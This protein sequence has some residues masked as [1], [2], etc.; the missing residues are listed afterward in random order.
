MS[1]IFN[2][3]I[4]TTCVAGSVLER[5][6]GTV[7]VSTSFESFTYIVEDVEGSV[8]LQSSKAGMPAFSDALGYI[9]LEPESE[10][11]IPWNTA[12]EKE[13][14]LKGD[15]VFLNTDERISPSGENG[16]SDIVTWV[17]GTGATQQLIAL[18]GELDMNKV[19]TF[20][21]IVQSLS[22]SFGPNDQVRFQNEAGL[23]VAEPI[24]LAQLNGKS[25]KYIYLDRQ[26]ALSGIEPDQEKLQPADNTATHFEVQS[27]TSGTLVI[28]GIKAEVGANDLVGGWV[29]KTGDE[30][31][32]VR[33]KILGNTASATGSSQLTL[34]VGTSN[35][36]LL[37]SALDKV[38]LRG[39]EQQKL[40]II[41]YVESTAALLFG[42]LF[43][44]PLPFRTAPIYQRGVRKI[45]VGNKVEYGVQHNPLSGRNTFGVFAHIHEMRGD[46][47]IVNFGNFSIAYESD[48]IVVRAKDTT[49][50]VSLSDTPKKN[51]KIYTGISVTSGA[52]FLVINGKVRARSNI[53]GFEG[54]KTTPMVLTSAGLRHLLNISVFSESF[55]DLLQV[56]DM[57]PA[58][59]DLDEMFYT[60]FVP[61][62]LMAKYVTQI[63]L[64]SVVIPQPSG[65]RETYR[66]KTINAATKVLTIGDG[67]FFPMGTPVR[68]VRDGTAVASAVVASVSGVSVTLDHTTGMRVDD[69]IVP[70][71]ELPESRV[72]VV[73]PYVTSDAQTIQSVNTTNKT[74]VVASALAMV[75]GLA[76][77][78]TSLNQQ[79]ARVVITKVFQE[80]RTLELS[81][82]TDIEAGFIIGQ[83]VPGTEL[84]VSPDNYFVSLAEPNTAVSF[85]VKASDG[86]VLA[87]NTVPA[88]M[89]VRPL[90]N[91]YM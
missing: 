43:L 12:L 16:D 21:A 89:E 91:I 34:D 73:F 20:S 49:L 62:E 82:M 1:N 33:F 11:L 8:F 7:P 54:S 67:S 60:D 86:V 30:A 31:T 13:Q 81:S 50:S 46:G 69:Y 44:E 61:S 55:D 80:T 4:F 25:E 72:A 28:D 66:I 19:Y 75:P 39:P 58:S 88:A 37:F 36:T 64:P 24:P 85:A 23:Q 78:Y 22:S 87:Q 29:V 52:I 27:V 53:T 2:K 3:A 6:S 63:A 57:I 35:L 59:S 9:Q 18:V 42:G 84:R 38:I 83:A 32:S 17:S 65:Y 26:L 68:I 71:R 10:N 41:F 56:G 14:Y 51:L 70:E 45:R 76:Y 5:L 90:L 74:V 48:S 15:N 79:V 40:K 47:N 77:V